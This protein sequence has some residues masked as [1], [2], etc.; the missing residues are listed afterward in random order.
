MCTADA[1]TNNPAVAGLLQKAQTKAP[2]QGASAAPRMNSRSPEFATLFRNGLFGFYGIPTA[3]TPSRQASPDTVVRV[4]S[5]NR[6]VTL[7]GK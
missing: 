1:A 3:Q 7:L 2:T 5:M 6:G 4:D